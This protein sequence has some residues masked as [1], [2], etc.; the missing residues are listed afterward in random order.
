MFVTT[1]DGTRPH[2]EEYGA[3]R[4]LVFVTS[5]MLDT[6]MREY[7]IPFFAERGYRCVTFDLDTLADD[8][9]A[10]ERMLAAIRAVADDLFLSHRDR[11]ADDILGFVKG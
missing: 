5:S 3:G 4:P 7:Q 6:E 9:A 11:L 10:L 8:L 1:T 2:Y